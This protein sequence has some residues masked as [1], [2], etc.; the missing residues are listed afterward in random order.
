MVLRKSI[1]FILILA[2]FLFSLEAESNDT[3]FNTQDVAIH[4]FDPVAYFTQQQPVPGSPEII[5]AWMGSTWQFDSEANRDLFI[6]APERYAPQ[7]GGYCAYA[8]AK[9]SR[10]PTNA[11]AW[12]IIDD[13]LYLNFSTSVR[14]LWRP[15][16]KSY[17]HSADRIWSRM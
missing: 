4:G 5:Y 11:F 2:G 3:I 10:A 8:M 13:K 16:A 17:I 1:P 9:G 14:S 15:N 12:S 6:R 7:Y